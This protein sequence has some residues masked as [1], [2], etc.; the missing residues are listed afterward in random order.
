MN[1]EQRTFKCHT[2][3]GSSPRR[4]GGARK[5]RSTPEKLDTSPEHKP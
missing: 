2:L 5:G 4:E 1:S 3:W